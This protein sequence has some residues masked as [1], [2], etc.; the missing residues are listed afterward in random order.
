MYRFRKCVHSLLS[1][2]NR[3]FNDKKLRYTEGS[4][5]WDVLQAAD[6]VNCRSRNF[7]EGQLAEEKLLE[8]QFKLQMYPD[9][10]EEM[11]IIIETFHQAT[12]RRAR[13]TYVRPKE[14]DEIF[15]EPGGV[16]KY[17]TNHK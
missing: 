6:L 4:L 1:L 7:K 8:I 3:L 5:L 12:I 2:K 16:L 13:V 9:L 11:E 14:I 10:Y 17:I 15:L